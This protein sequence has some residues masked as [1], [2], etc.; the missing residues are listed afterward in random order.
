MLDGKGMGEA[1]VGLL[2]IGLIVGIVLG[3]GGCW[4][5]GCLWQHLR[6]T[7]E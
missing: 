7:W 6:V 4:V 3:L 5:G 2:I 1:M